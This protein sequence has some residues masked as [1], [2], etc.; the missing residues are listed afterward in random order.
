MNPYAA[1]ARM[2]R[3]PDSFFGRAV[4]LSGLYT[5]LAALQSCSLVGPRRIGKS[6][7]LYHLTQPTIY[8]AHLP[9]PDP[10][11]FAFV[12]L[13]ELAGLGPDDLFCTA[14][15]RLGQ[16][17]GGR[18]AADPARDGT[19]T[20]F[21]RFLMRATDAGWRLVLCCDE[22]EM[23]SQ[24]PR[25]D[26]DLFTYLRGLCN[27]Y[28][29]ALVTSSRTSLYDLCHQGNLQT[30]Q[31]WNIFVERRL[32]LMPEDEALSLIREPFA[33]AG[34]P[35]P[36]RD[37][38]FALELAGCH[39]F[40][41]QIACY[42]LF[43]AHAKGQVP[44]H[45][46]V[47]QQFLRE[48]SRHYTYAWKQLDEAGQ[49]ALAALAR[50]EG[51]R[52]D[53]ATFQRLKDHALLTGSPDAPVILS[54][55]WREFAKS[56]AP[57]QPPPPPLPPLPR[58]ELVYADFDLKVERTDATT[59]R[60][61]VL[62]SPAGQDSAR[63]RLPFP[64]EEAGQV[65]IDLGQQVS[66][67]GAVPRPGR[68]SPVATGEALFRA[69]FAGVVGQLFFES[70]GAVRSQRQ[71]LR[72]KIHVDPE[73]SPE[74]AALP[75]EYLYNHRRRAFISLNRL[76]PIIRYLDVQAP[77]DRPRIQPPLRVLVAIAS[78]LDQ[79]PLDVPG[80]RR[81]IEQAW[82]GCAGVTVEFLE[83]ATPPALQARLWDWQPHALHFTGHGT[84]DDGTGAGALLFTDEQ[85]GSRPV[86]GSQLAMLLSNAPSVRLAYLNACQSAELSRSRNL[87]PFSGVAAALVLAGLPAVVAMQ[88]PIS[89]RSALAF[90]NGFYPRLAAGEAVDVAVAA[91]RETVCLQTPDSPEWGTPVLFMRIPDG[92]LFDMV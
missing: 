14:V 37:V 7:L 66:R 15:E 43:E 68:A 50:A 32:G 39:P 38:A 74:L 47:E 1:R 36:D 21:R 17:S 42:H 46:T 24:N 78:P 2:I 29:L 61:L 35:L 88:F 73:A 54:R 27:S 84:F 62:D 82:G 33:R 89:D 86:T 87:D 56:Q 44:D 80:E 41:L 30:S 51:E 75:W 91:G 63:V 81:L 3:D 69:I 85:G 49:R 53:A 76:T 23:L 65:M 48:A 71:G 79:P 57:S 4:E 70:L 64:L 40:F 22:F 28:N 19:A 45:G 67:G 26:A 6:S 11:L 25:F 20:G 9:D 34:V 55:S 77:T 8:P 5:L 52:L 92:H 58:T 10:Y 16:A 12:D 60:V 90:A 72:I 59:C 83:Q 31:F 13:Q 18:L